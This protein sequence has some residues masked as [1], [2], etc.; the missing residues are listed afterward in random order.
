MGV[1]LNQHARQLDIRRRLWVPDPLPGVDLVHGEDHSEKVPRVQGVSETDWQ[2][3]AE[4]GERLG[5]GG[6]WRGCG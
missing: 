4:D 1:L 6:G 5:G 2:V 3:C